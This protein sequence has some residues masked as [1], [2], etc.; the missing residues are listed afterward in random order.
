[1]AIKNVFIYFV[2]PA[3]MRPAVLSL[4]IYIVYI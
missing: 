3:A 1:M 2:D 4:Y